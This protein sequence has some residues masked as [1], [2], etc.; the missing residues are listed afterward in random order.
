MPKRRVISVIC[1][2]NSDIFTYV[3]LFFPAESNEGWVQFP[4]SDGESPTEVCGDI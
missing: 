2:Y 4:T 3:N 1:T